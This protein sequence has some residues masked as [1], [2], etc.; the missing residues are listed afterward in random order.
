MTGTSLL[1]NSPRPPNDVNHLYFLLRFF[2][3][4][5]F[6]HLIFPSFCFH[7]FANLCLFLSLSDFSLCLL[8]H[9]TR[10]QSAD[11]GSMCMMNWAGTPAAQVLPRVHGDTTRG[12]L[13]C[14]A[15][16]FN[17]LLLFTHTWN[18]WPRL[19]R[20]N[21]P[22]SASNIVSQWFIHNT[23]TLQ[24]KNWFNSGEINALTHICRIVFATVG[25]FENPSSLSLADVAYSIHSVKKCIPYGQYILSWD[26]IH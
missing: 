6:I 22:T 16:T 2:S 26:E 20:V 13:L 24:D 11:S 7:V 21:F 25:S 5:L 18:S 23:R 4:F 1:S 10:L 15:V 14:S 8:V 12:K 3:F 9:P 19:Q 17:T